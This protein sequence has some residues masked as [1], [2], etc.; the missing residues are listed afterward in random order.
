LDVAEAIAPGCRLREIGIRPGE[1][2]HEEMI[3][4]TDA[5][6]TIEFKDYFVILPS[7]DF[8]NIK[9]FT[10]TFHGKPCSEDFRY[11]SGTNSQWL[12]VAQIRQ[13]V[14]EFQAH[15]C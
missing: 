4:E 11:C 13:L 8:L 5:L 6:N 10:T 9:E 14:Q 1:K 15:G 3:T 12:S 7:M 2:L